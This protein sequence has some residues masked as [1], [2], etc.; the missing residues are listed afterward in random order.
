MSHT[1]DCI[2]IGAGVMGASLAFHLA[3]RGLKVL[4][5]ER[6]TQASGAT[7]HSS[8][9]IRM[10]YDLV[11]ES[12]LAFAG[13]KYFANWHERVGGEC[14]FTKTGF[15]HIAK[16]EHEAQ[17]RG[18]VALQQKIGVNTGIISAAEVKHML[19]DFVT[20]EFEIAAYEPDS[21]YGDAT[22]A[23]SSLLNAAKQRGAM[24]IQNCAVTGI[25]VGGG[26]VTGVS[27]PQG[28]FS[29]S[30]IVNAAGPWAAQVAALV[31]VS[32]PLET[33][34][35]D[36]A[37][38][39]RPPGLG[40]IPTVIDDT[41]GSYFR[42]E[43]GNL[44]LAAGEEESMR[45]EAPD[46]ES[47][48]VTPAFLDKLIDNLCKRVP[49]FEQSGLQSVHVGRDGLTPDQRPILG[50]AGPEGFY[51]ACGLSGTGFK[52]SPAAGLCLAELIVEGRAQTVDIT[53]FR[54]E[55]FA[56]G[57]LLRGEFEYGNGWK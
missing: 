4:V 10:H 48:T 52:I 38:L 45:G 34:T 49:K 51:L 44:I 17:L 22:L 35:H 23:T 50:A 8:G 21:G 53:P 18:N 1:Y 46:E 13:F 41:I 39:H 24:L 42:P 2:I 6:H 26:R 25:T 28:E 36:V 33:W 16:R 3:E 14:G 27:T 37:F 57:Q 11:V 20:D 40:P 5:L 19:P 7:G 43:G 31:R 29:A 54:F 47:Q 55:R 9:L 32:V 15:L 12:E 30:V 56:E